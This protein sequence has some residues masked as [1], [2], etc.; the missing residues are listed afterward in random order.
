[1]G[2]YTARNNPNA[3]IHP[4]A[5]TSMSARYDPVTVGLRIRMSTAALSTTYAA[6]VRGAATSG[7]A[8]GLEKKL[9]GSP[10]Q[11]AAMFSS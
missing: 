2:Q 5:A 10:G 1:M 7:G 6:T 4:A 11:A 3:M 8:L 9:A